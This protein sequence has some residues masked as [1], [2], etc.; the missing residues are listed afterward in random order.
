MTFVDTLASTFDLGQDED[1]PP[2]R[3]VYQNTRVLAT[4]HT[5][6][7]NGFDGAIGSGPE[8]PGGG[9][10]PL[11]GRTAQPFRIAGLQTGKAFGGQP[12]TWTLTVKA[13]RDIDVMRLWR[14][15]EDVW[16][17]IVVMKNGK[18]REVLLGLINTVT[19]DTNRS[20]V[21]ARA[22]IYTITG[23][24][25]QKVFLM[26]QL[27]INVHENAGQ[28]PIIPMYAAVGEKIFG[29]PEQIVGLLVDAWLGNNGVADKQWRMPRSLAGGNY[30]FNVLRKQ[31][32]KC[33]G[34]TRDP[35]LYDPSQLQGQNLWQTLE[36]YSNGILNELYTEIGNDQDYDPAKKPRPRLRLRERPFPTRSKG[37]SVWNAV[38]THVLKLGDVNGR[39]VSKG[40]PESRFN[41]WLLDATGLSGSGLAVQMQIQQAAGVEKGQPGGAP[42]YNIEDMR[43]HGFRK[44]MQSTRYFPFRDDVNWLTHSARW[45]H[46]LHDWYAIT[47]YELSG[48]LVL[49]TIR[50][51]IQIGHRVTERRPFG[52]DVT[53]YVEGVQHGW[54]YPGPGGTT[55]SVTRGEYGDEDLLDL[56]YENIQESSGLGSAIEAAVGLVQN[57]P[58]GNEIP[59]GSGVKMDQVVGQIDTPERTYLKQRGKTEDQEHIRRGELDSP[60]DA[61]IAE[62]E[63]TDLPDQQTTQ[64]EEVRVGRA[65]PRARKDGNLTQ[66]ELESGRRL[67][68]RESG[69]EKQENANLTDDQQRAKWRRNR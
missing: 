3:A 48:T 13:G 52:P 34:E 62:L 45:L 9:R 15:P 53:Y 20:G 35:A 66:D 36:Q 17:R 39:N 56:L 41:Y 42:I 16:A 4:F 8:I 2:G 49:S 33:R 26:T 64:E 55:L 43:R 10:N 37:N 21:G 68:V 6:Q 69:V 1:G 27:Y 67:P 5:D 19:E 24:D 32:A 14:D 18:P 40:A 61:R 58:L 11:G 50:P 47:P 23:F 60:D 7:S 12:G 65:K 22:A 57:T 31:F 28:L 30:F 54:Q 38:R 29:P 59:H 63:A 46:M 44:F 25:F 51:E